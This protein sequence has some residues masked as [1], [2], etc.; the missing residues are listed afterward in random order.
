MVSNMPMQIISLSSTGIGFQLSATKLD[1][2]ADPT[3]EP[4][5]RKLTT[6]ARVYNKRYLCG[7]VVIPITGMYQAEI[8]K[9]TPPKQIG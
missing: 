1:T 6:L 5:R 9:K 2:K 7:T 8:V 4:R 3:I